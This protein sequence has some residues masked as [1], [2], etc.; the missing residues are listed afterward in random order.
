MSPNSHGMLRICFKIGLPRCKQENRKQLLST[1]FSNASID[2]LHRA[3]SNPYLM[4]NNG[5]VQ[6]YKPYAKLSA[7]DS[8]ARMHV[9]SKMVVKIKLFS[10]F[11]YLLV[12]VIPI[13]TDVRQR[14]ILR[15]FPSS[16][17]KPKD[18]LVGKTLL[19]NCKG[20]IPPCT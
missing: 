9:S 14:C 15:T 6:A 2:G 19:Q 1:H 11:M 16:V 12:L 13:N 7:N 17:K 18:I 8:L 10:I 4:I 20:R 5:K 3:S